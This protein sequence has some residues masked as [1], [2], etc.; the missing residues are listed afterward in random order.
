MATAVEKLAELEAAADEY[1]SLERARLNAQYDFLDAIAK[2][3]GA[4]I[5]L[6]DLNAAGASQILVNSINEYLGR[7]LKPKGV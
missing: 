7:P 1:F 2:K 4:G 6:Q 5:S 3:R